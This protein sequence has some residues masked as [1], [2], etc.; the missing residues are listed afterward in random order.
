[1]KKKKKKSPRLAVVFIFLLLSASILAGYFFK[2]N[3]FGGFNKVRVGLK[4][5]NQAQFAGIY[6]A[7][8]K[9]LYKKY[10]LDVAIKEFDFKTSQI[11]DLL[12]GN[13]DFAFV[14]PE[15][16]LLAIDEG[17][18]IKAIGAIYQVSPYAIISLKE[19]NI[20]TPAD[21]MGKTLGNEGGKLEG[22]MIYHLLLDS[23]GLTSSDAKIVDLDFQFSEFQDLTQKKADAIQLYR[24][25]QLYI[26]D[27]EASDYNVIYPEHFGINMFNDVVVTREDTLK[28]S[29]E[30]VEEFLAGTVEGWEYA[31]DNPEEAVEYSIK[32]VTKDSYLD[33]DYESFI[34][35]QSIPLVKPDVKSS[36]G[37]MTFSQWDKLYQHILSGGFI[38]GDFLVKDVFTT[39]FLP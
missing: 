10:G 34:L 36:V 27:K 6:T 32:Y 12:S 21:F 13:T 31:I 11:D 25:D 19:S 1:M 18:P 3:P 17:K 20:N 26:F 7:K 15:E 4:W 23:V 37:A 5:V 16:V 24:T 35:K 9:L 29:P 14:S 33:R 22:E 2:R 39:D 30:L 38:K 28:N 8:E